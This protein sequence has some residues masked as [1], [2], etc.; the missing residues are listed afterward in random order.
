MFICTDLLNSFDTGQTFTESAIDYT[1]ELTQGQPWLVNALAKEV[2]LVDLGLL[3]RRDDGGLIVAN[4][5]YREILPL[6]LAQGAQD[7]L[8]TIAPTWLSANGEF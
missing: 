6:V 8:P 2:Y 7:G 4:P 1:F 5:I 3:R